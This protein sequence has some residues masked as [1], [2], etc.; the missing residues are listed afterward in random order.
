MNDV[1]ILISL[2]TMVASTISFAPTTIIVLRRLFRGQ[3]AV[4]HRANGYTLAALMVFQLILFVNSWAY[5]HWSSPLLLVLV[6]V[7]V[8]TLNLRSWL[9]WKRF[10]SVDADAVSERPE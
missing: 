1:E 3:N 4:S 8:C 9:E 10:L 7:T 5:E 6:G 2:I